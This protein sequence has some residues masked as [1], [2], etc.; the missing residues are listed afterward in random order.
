MQ[1][2]TVIAH[3]VVAPSRKRLSSIELLRIISMLAICVFHAFQTISGHFG[4]SNGLA[5]ITQYGG[6]LGN[7]IFV[8]CS[9]WFLL[10][11]KRAKPERAISILADSTFISVAIFLIVFASMFQSLD[12]RTSEIIH[13]FLPDLF[14]Q[15]WFIPCYVLMYL[16]HPLF[17]AAISKMGP[18][19]HLVLIILGFLLYGVLNGVGA[20][21][22]GSDLAQFAVIY[23]FVGYMKKYAPRFCESTKWNFV[24][25]GVTL[26]LLMALFTIKYLLRNQPQAAQL[27]SFGITKCGLLMLFGLCVFNLFRKMHF[28]SRFINYTA[29]A[30]LFVYCIHENYMLRTYVRPL[31]YDFCV[32]QFPGVPLF[33]FG[34]VCGI[35]MFIGGYLIAIVYKESIHRLTVMLAKGIA[36]LGSKGI[37][38]LENWRLKHIA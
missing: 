19:P 38:A 26:L 14:N 17:N 15:L 4:S 34:L 31:F 16:L 30:T 2:E 6:Q 3:N 24:I 36:V 28:E 21:V 22:P 8:I 20:A 23:F 10:D 27:F 29:S 37:N 33:W 1:E 18:K 9:A 13:Q 25:G 5:A 11:S 12:L 32:Q 35:G 7:V